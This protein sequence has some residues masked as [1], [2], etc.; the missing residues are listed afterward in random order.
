MLADVRMASVGMYV[1]GDV[2]TWWVA[3]SDGQ[4]LEQSSV[5]ST[6]L[7]RRVL[8][9]WPCTATEM[10]WI[11]WFQGCSLSTMDSSQIKSRAAETND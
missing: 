1:L 6:R 7:R 9:R 8:R 3:A 2:Y 4:C 11:W 5:I 10:H